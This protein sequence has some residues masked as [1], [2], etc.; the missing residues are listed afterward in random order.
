MSRPRRIT[1]RELL[2]TARKVFLRRGVHAPV[3]A[4]A[5]ELGVSVAALFFR[6]KSKEQLLSQALLPPFPP[7]EVTQLAQESPPDK[8]PRARLLALLS[9]LCDFLP[10]ALPGFF[11][12]HTA[13]VLP[14]QKSKSDTIDVV[15]RSALAAWMRRARTRKLISIADP[16]ATADAVIGA[17]EA[18]FLHAYLLKR[19]FSPRQNRAFVRR[20][21]VA[22]LGPEGTG[23]RRA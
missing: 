18:R 14:M 21:L 2:A 19:T 5:K 9:G 20:L 8:I 13:G 23:R 12:L 15:M 10:E 7:P 1:D 17:M 11:L 22:T 6:M 3:S 16:S 4:V